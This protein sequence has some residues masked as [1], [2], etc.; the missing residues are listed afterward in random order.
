MLLQWCIRERKETYETTAGV[1]GLVDGSVGL[2]AVG[3]VEQRREALDGLA[4]GTG[5]DGFR[6]RVE[7][8][9]S[10]GSACLQHGSSHSA[11]SGGEDRNEGVHVHGENDWNCTLVGDVQVCW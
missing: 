3:D 7:R 10:N 6:P 9:V 11:G 4:L 1:A 8:V 5:A 2:A